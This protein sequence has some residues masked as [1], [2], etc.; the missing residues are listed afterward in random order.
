MISASILRPISADTP[1]IAGLLKLSAA[2]AGQKSLP[3]LLFFSPLIIPP[4]SHPRAPT[5]PHTTKHRPKENITPTHIKI[6]S[7]PPHHPFNPCRQ[8]LPVL[9][10]LN[11]TLPVIPPRTYQHLFTIRRHRTIERLGMVDLEA[12]RERGCGCAG[13]GRRWAGGCGWEGRW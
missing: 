6:R 12:G 13:A 10:I 3:A 5:H 4:V 2:L 8:I 7:L 9:L 11:P 1:S